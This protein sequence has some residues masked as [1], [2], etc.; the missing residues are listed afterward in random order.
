MEE[1]KFTFEEGMKRLEPFL[2]AGGKMIMYDEQG[3]KLLYNKCL[4][5][6]Q[7]YVEAIPAL[8]ASNVEHQKNRRVL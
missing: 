7:R 3:Y 4:F 1:K 8:D 6:T 2:R 5:E